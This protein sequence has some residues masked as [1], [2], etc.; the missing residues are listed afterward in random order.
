MSWVGG[1]TVLPLEASDLR[2]AFSERKSLLRISSLSTASQLS[3]SVVIS[4][5]R[6]SFCSDVRVDSQATL[7]NL[8]GTGAGAAS[9]LSVDFAVGEEAGW[10]DAGWEDLVAADG[11]DLGWPKKE[12][13][14]PLGLGFFAASAARST[15]LRLRDISV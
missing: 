12:V 9:A 4:S 3:C 2:K 13:M 14:E 8:A 6:R 11:L 15:A 1:K 5:R 7:S 10:E